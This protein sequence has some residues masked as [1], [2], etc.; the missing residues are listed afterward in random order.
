M[1][2]R[3]LNLSKIDPLDRGGRPQQNTIFTP[4]AATRCQDDRTDEPDR[5]PALLGH[6]FPPARGG[7]GDDGDGAV[8]VHAD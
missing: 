6:V 3:H 1:Q 8:R 4:P 2:L 7:G 5:A